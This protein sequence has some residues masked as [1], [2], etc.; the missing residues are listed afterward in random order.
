M[1]LGDTAQT[2]GSGPVPAQ[3]APQTLSLTLRLWD[4]YILEGK[5]AHCHGTVLGAY[6]S[7]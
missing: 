5:H 6:R 2:R 3:A 7:K 4:A 1:Q